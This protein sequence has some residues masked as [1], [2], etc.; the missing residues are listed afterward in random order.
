[1]VSSYLE[2]GERR[3]RDLASSFRSQ[4]KLSGP[5]KLELLVSVSYLMWVLVIELR[6]FGR[7]VNAPNH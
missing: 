4:R 7:A 3:G 2:A 5:L 1:M 6:F